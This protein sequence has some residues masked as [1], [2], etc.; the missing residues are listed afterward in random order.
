MTIQNKEKE[1]LMGFLVKRGGFALRYTICFLSSLSCFYANADIVPVQILAGSSGERAGVLVAQAGECA[2]LT[3]AHGLTD[4]VMKVNIGNKIFEAQ[5]GWNG[6]KS[7][8]HVDIALLRINSAIVNVCDPL[9]TPERIVEGLT[10]P[11]GQIWIRE[12]D[13]GVRTITASITQRNDHE[14]WLQQEGTKPRAITRGASGAP[15]VFGGRVVAILTGNTETELRATRLDYLLEI[16]GNETRLHKADTV[17]SRSLAAYDLGQLTESIA[18]SVREAR[19]IRGAAEV[20]AKLAQDVERRA[21][22]A[23]RYAEDIP[24][25]QVI[26]GHSRFSSLDG[27]YYAGQVVKKFGWSPHIHSAG[28]GVLSYEKGNYKGDVLKCAFHQIRHTCDGPFVTI[29]RDLPSA[30]W[31]RLE[32]E[33][34]EHDGISGPSKIF[35]RNGAIVFGKLTSK[36]NDNGVYTTKYSGNVVFEYSDGYRYE[37]GLDEKGRNGLGVLWNPNGSLGYQGQWIDDRRG[38]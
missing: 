6:E 22:E 34:S 37:G 16:A 30:S 3:A 19:E 11:Y 12:S 4:I 14:I 35:L 26:N 33:W 18:S 36:S 31:K 32:A 23:K 2:I 17:A 28:Y 8:Y 25:G 13:S 1:M 9:A 38:D 21:D 29:Y 5:R 15:V 20:V 27:N 24:Q 7:K 10:Q